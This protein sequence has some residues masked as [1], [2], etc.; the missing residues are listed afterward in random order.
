MEQLN[1]ELF[2]W[3]ISQGLI[4]SYLL[5]LVYGNEGTNMVYNLVGGTLGSLVMGV[6]SVVMGIYGSVIFAFLGNVT[7]LFLMNVFHQHHVED[8]LG[9]VE[10]GIRIK[11]NRES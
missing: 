1:G 5:K 11:G 6:L 7:V 8:M 9:H 2:F 4:V 10:T 3:F